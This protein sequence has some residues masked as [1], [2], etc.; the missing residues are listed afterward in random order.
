MG[1][2]VAITV[3]E[4]NGNLW[5]MDRWT[6]IIPYFFSHVSLYNGQFNAWLEEFTDSWK[7]INRTTQKI[8]ILPINIDNTK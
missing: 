7:V 6:N 1:G 3:K 2:N 5:K 8:I 4:E